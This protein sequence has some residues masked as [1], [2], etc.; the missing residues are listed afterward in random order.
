MNRQNILGKKYGKL[1]VIEFSRLNKWRQAVWQCE[2][3]CGEY[4]KATTAE[5]NSGHKTSCGCYRK[6][7]SRKRHWKG[8]EEIGLDHWNAI[9][10]RAKSHGIPFDLTIS[11]AWQLY[12]DQNRK[13]ALTGW[14]IEFDK[15]KGG[16][17]TASLDR[18]NSKLGY[19]KS[20][21]QWTHKKVNFCKHALDNNSFIELCNGVVAFHRMKTQ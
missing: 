21:V 18:I 10:R 5:L 8:Y 6:E 13:C 7:A 14:T 11:D 17:Q 12:V 2:C 1:T 15:V 4:T 9:K 20:N 19:V 16:K 3:I